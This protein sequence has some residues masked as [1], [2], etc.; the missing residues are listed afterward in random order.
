MKTKIWI[1]IGA[2]AVLL[3]A[4]LFAAAMTANR[5]DFT[6]LGTDTF[7]TSEYE[8]GD[9]IRDISVSVSDADVVFAPADGEKCRVAVYER[10]NEPH[11]V[12]VSDGTLSV[13]V[14]DEGEWFD[15]IGINVGSP[16]VTVY[17]PEKEYSALKVE[18]TTC[19]VTVPSCFTFERAEISVT[20]GD[21]TVNA[22][23]SDSLKIRSTTGDITVGG[24]SARRVELSVTTGDVTV[25]DVKCS[26]SVAVGVT[27]GEVKVENLTC[28]VFE[29]D[30][31]TGDIT[32]KNVKASEKITAE[33]STGDVTI[34]DSDAPSL[35]IETTT[36]DVSGSLRTE[37]VFLVHTSTG[38]VSVPATVT[39]GRCEITT[40]TG[41]VR[42]D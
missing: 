39:G 23:V 17:L 33:R 38:N 28:A 32:L 22:P 34:L 8:F 41:D 6:A 31:S 3:G 2:F 4:V 16:R 10:E 14:N 20:T 13:S 35:E 27:T 7:R 24:I 21:L 26:G 1:W 40:S 29:S 18:G 30:G 9:T 37:K 25:S 5:W 36:G 19:G 11:T 15:H 42:F 12:T